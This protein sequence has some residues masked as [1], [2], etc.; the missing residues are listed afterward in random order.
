M[1]KPLLHTK[2]TVKLRKS[3]YR[4]EWYLVVESYPIRKPD[5]G[6]P[7]RIIESVNRIITTPI[8]DTTAITGFDA[9]GNYKYKPK[10]DTNGIILCTSRLDREACV[11]ADKVRALRQQEYDTAVVYSDREQEMIAQN[12]RMEQDFIAY[13]N[14]II[15]KVHPNS[16]NSIIV[17]WTRVGKLLSIFSEGKPIPFR[18]INVKLLEDLKLFMLT[19]PQG[20][21]KKG[22]LSQNSAATYFSIVKAGLHRAFIDEYLTVDIAAK[23]KGIP[24]LKVK[25]ET[26]T[27]EEAE[28]LAQ[29]PCENEV[30]KRAFFFAILTGIRLCDI[31][32]LTWGEIQKT[33]TGWRVDFTQRKTHVVDYLPINEQAYSLCGEPG[34]HDQQIFA[35]LTGSSWISRPLKKWIAASGIKKHITFHCS[36]HTFATLQ[37][38]N[39]TDIFVVKGM[40]GHTN[41]KTTQIY[42]HIVDKSKRN[43][44]EV[45]QID[46]L[47][48][49]NE[50]L[51]NAK[52]I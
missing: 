42:A 27:L 33:S 39:G 43:A 35:G 16:S 9:D 6:K 52:V 41:V 23:V 31:H 10:R 25:R 36:R 32:E 47:N 18:K 44:A 38:E 50:S 34:E 30:L 24:E 13:F 7:G 46:G 17:N 26:L 12:E 49:S 21:N 28:L 22:T 8:W 15:Y 1:R 2:V 11:Y 20:G 51:D 45:L 37:L 19:A 48:T 14:S 29:T 4:E 40:L 3:E 5:G